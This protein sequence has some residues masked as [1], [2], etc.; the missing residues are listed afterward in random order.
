MYLVLFLGAA[1]AQ[2]IAAQWIA[3]AIYGLWVVGS[4]P[5][6][7]IGGV[8]NGIRPQLLIPSPKTRSEKSPIQGF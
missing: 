3:L 5:I 1:V 4:T 8:R 2:W 7:V 6:R